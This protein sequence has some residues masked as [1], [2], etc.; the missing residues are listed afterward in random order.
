MIRYIFKV[1]GAGGEDITKTI[2]ENFG[3]LTVYVKMTI[4]I[5]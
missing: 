1:E 5:S 4:D 3:G 2:E